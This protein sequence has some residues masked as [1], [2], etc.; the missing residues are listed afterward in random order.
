MSKGKLGQEVSESLGR[1]I[2]ARL[3]AI[4]FSRAHL[5]PQARNPIYLIIDEADSFIHGISLEIILKETRK[6]GLSLF[7]STQN[8]VSGHEQERLKRNLL[9]N[10]QIKVIGA[11]G[12]STLQP[13]GKE[14]RIPIERL[15]QLKPHHF[16]IKNGFKMPKRLHLPH[17]LGSLSGVLLDRLQV[18]SLNDYMVKSTGYYKPI[19]NQHVSVEERAKDFPQDLF[20]D[21]ESRESPK[22]KFTL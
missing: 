22:A 3:K 18:R 7:L 15:Q 2:I 19:L 17:V 14:T 21:L 1:F 6:Y 9:N 5:P 12:L 13:L 11:N 20:E 8:L 10:T 4:A 16:R